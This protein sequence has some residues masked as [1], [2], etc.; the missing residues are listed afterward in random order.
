MTVE[1]THCHVMDHIG[2]TLPGPAR[3][4]EREGSAYPWPRR[5][6]R[7]YSQ[8][9]RPS[10]SAIH[11]SKFSRCGRSFLP[12]PF[13][14]FYHVPHFFARLL[15][16]GSASRTV[17]LTPIPLLCAGTHHREPNLPEEYPPIGKRLFQT[18]DRPPVL[19]SLR[20]NPYGISRRIHRPNTF[21][22]RSVLC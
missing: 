10:P 5:S 20:P 7:R 21:E 17:P 9:R 8:S 13:F 12:F 22:E 11:R 3:I 19:S 16:F 2:R 6:I 4:A 1:Q 14:K 15:A 18:R